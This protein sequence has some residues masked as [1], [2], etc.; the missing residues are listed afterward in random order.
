MSAIAAIPLTIPSSTAHAPSPESTA[1]T[2]LLDPALA[3][4]ARDKVHLLARNRTLCVSTPINIDR[5]AKEFSNHPNRDFV[6]NLIQDLHFGTHV[7]YS[8]PEKPRISRNLIWGN[9]HPELVSKYLTKEISL[10]RVAGPFD[11]PPLPNLQCHPVGVVPK[12]H[13]SEWGTIYHRSYPEGDSLNDFIPKDPY[14]FQYVRLD[15]AIHILKSLG[16]GSFMAK[17]DLKSA[18]RLIPDH[19]DHWHLL[20]IYWQSQY[21]I[22]LYLPFG[23]RSAPF[24]FNRLCDALERVLKNNYNVKNV[25]HILDDFFMAV[26][27][28]MKC[29]SSFSTLLRLFMSVHAPV[30]PSKTLAPS[31][32]LEFVGIELDSTRMEA[33]LPEDKLLRTSSVFGE[34]HSVL[35]LE[36]QSLIGT[37]QFACKAVV[38]GRTYLQR[39]IDLTRGVRNCFHHIRLNKQFFK[40]L[41]MWKTFQAGWNGRS[42]F[43][44]STVTPSPD[45]DLYANASSTIGF[46][47]YFRGK[48]FQ[49]RW[50]SHMQLNKERGISIEW[51]KLFPIVVA[52]AIWF[53]PILPNEQT[54]F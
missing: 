48:W 45:M 37:L 11:H 7:G 39:M 21:Y 3:T 6:Y 18:F 36:L 23:L 17:T 32:V 28:R 20:G 52:C 43:L 14:A 1:T 41:N 8:G 24:L 50:P 54:Y 35:L 22:D 44:D 51:P 42:F 40:D 4:A 15:D 53:P 30:V 13:S 19:P 34:H 47:G 27:S 16:P 9:Q 25:I 31:Q 33:R 38:P 10:G 5:L 2:D 46:G 29:L 12:K 26:P 49:G